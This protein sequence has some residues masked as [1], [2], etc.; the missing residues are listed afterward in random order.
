MA[1]VN[2]N[3]TITAIGMMGGKGCFKIMLERRMTNENGGR[4]DKIRMT[5]NKM[6]R[7]YKT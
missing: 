4:E 1:D 6:A 7:L 5:T 2:T 3:Q